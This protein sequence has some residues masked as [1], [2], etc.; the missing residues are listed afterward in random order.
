MK[1]KL[2]K[3][4]IQISIFIILIVFGFSLF[5]NISYPLLWNDEASTAMF[6][7]RVLEYGYP[8]VHD[9]KNSLYLF[10]DENHNIALREKG[11]VYI[12]EGWAQYY[13]SA[14]GGYFA[15]KTDNIYFKT[16]LLRTPFAIAGFL[17][18]I[19]FGLTFSSFFKKNNKAKAFLV[20]LIFE[21]VSISLVLHL[22]EIRYY[23][24]ILFFSAILINIYCRYAI[25]KNL[26][27]RY[28]IWFLPIFLLLLF[29]THHPIAAIFMLTF[30]IHSLIL[31]LKDDYKNILDFIKRLWKYISPLMISLIFIIPS[32]IYF[33]TFDLVGMVSSGSS[34]G[35][36]NYTSNIFVAISFFTKFEFLYLL[37]FLKIIIFSFLI[38]NKKIILEKD[39]II[40]NI[41]NFLLLLFTI[42]ILVIA[43]TVFV[44]ERYTIVLQPVLVGMIIFDTYLLWN[45][46]KNK[47]VKN[48]KDY[49]SGIK[50]F[51]GVLFVVI[52][53][54]MTPMMPSIKGHIY[55]ISHQYKGP[56]D[57]VVPYIIDKYENPSKLIIATNY[58]EN[59]FMYYLDSKTIIGYVG[60]NLQE[61]MK[62]TPDIIIPRKY[63]IFDQGYQ[64]LFDDFLAKTEYERI[65]FPVYDYPFNNIPELNF[66]PTHLYKTKIA[67]SDSETLYI[68]IKK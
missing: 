39:K 34:L 3:I 41:S 12:G 66:S 50:I 35:I 38:F 40:F 2:I 14:L 13:L 55:E 30:G 6:G 11:D 4:L 1:K 62:L 27:Y 21:T 60:N 23:S 49:R 68:Y 58:E 51:L 8:K 43:R 19:I 59:S 25:L 29:H 18:V 28:Y 22:R 65:N 26:K 44:F 48:D 53:M 15:E 32:I 16:A 17:A 24:L 56:L 63:F 61:D 46:I 64:D 54:N 42:Y 67:D 37:L 9:E 7:Q 52:Y 47:F 5:K 20:F 36:S 10:K 31:S 45:I 57:F 33:K